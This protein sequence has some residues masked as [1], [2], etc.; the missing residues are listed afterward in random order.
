[1]NAIN[2]RFLANA[3]K[4]IFL[5]AIVM[6]MLFISRTALIERPQIANAVVVDLTLS[7]PLAYLFFIRRTSV[8]KLAA[9]PVFVFGLFFAAWLVP[10]ETFV[11]KILKIVV[12]PMLEFG[13][14]SFAGYTIFKARKTYQSLKNKGFDQMENLRETLAAEFPSPVLGKALAFEIGVFYYAFFKWRKAAP[15]ENSF[16]YHREKGIAA[17]LSIFIFLVLAE[18]IV[19][20]FVLMSQNLIAAAWILT[21]LSVYFVFQIFAHLK[22]VLL[23]PIAL[24]ANEIFVRCGIIGDAKI[25][26]EKIEKIE[27]FNRDF[28]KSAG[29]L[30]AVAAGKLT[31]PNVRIILREDAIFTGFYGI[32]KNFKTIYLA[33]DEAE[34]FQKTVENKLSNN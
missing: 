5:F 30:K 8:S 15:R 16:S 14:L 13:V 29:A 6:T 17:L 28:E 18:T 9:I 1:M 33:V 7:L 25:E 31:A 11:L 22:A 3:T 4:A 12:F 19:I 24:G 2:F 10:S 20:H 26:Y 27:A 23:R 21:A 34:K 32:E